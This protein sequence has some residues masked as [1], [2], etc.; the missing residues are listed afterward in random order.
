VIAEKAIAEGRRQKIEI[1]EVRLQIA[2]AKSS[3]LERSP[4]LRFYFCN[5]QSDFCNRLSAP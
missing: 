5:L 3:F 2:E 1:A 4:I